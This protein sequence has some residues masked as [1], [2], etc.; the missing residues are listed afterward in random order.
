MSLVTKSN[1]FFVAQLVKNLPA[2]WETWAWSLG[3]EDPL[4]KGTPTHSSILTWR[5]P[6]IEEPGRLWSMGSQTIYS[7][8]NTVRRG[9]FS[10]HPLQCLLLADFLMMAILIGV[11]WYHFSVYVPFVYFCFYFI[12]CLRQITKK[13]CCNLCQSVFCL[14]SLLTIYHFDFIFVTV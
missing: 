5:I 11:R 12:F 7:A 2:M 1:V 9:P 14:C 4:E 6:W 3:W 10:P 13:Y 8:T